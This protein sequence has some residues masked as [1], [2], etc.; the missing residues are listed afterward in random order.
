MAEIIH[1]LNMELLG[2]SANSYFPEQIQG[3]GNCKKDC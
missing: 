2:T 1:M 3:K